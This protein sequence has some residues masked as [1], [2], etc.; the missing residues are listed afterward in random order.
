MDKVFLR[1]IQMGQI[2]GVLGVVLGTLLG[3]ICLPLPK[4][5]GKN[6]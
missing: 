1:G 3:N 5:E 2:G 6:Q 4:K